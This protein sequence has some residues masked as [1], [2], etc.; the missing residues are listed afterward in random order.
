MAEQVRLR[1]TNLG[2]RFFAFGIPVFAVVAP[3][4]LIGGNVALDMR[5]GRSFEKV[6][7]GSSEQS[8]E[9]LM[10][11]PNKK[12][13]CGEDLWWDDYLGKNDGR[14][15]TESRY[16]YFLSAWGIGYSQDGLVVSKYHYQSE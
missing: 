16:E 9:A 13:A 1:F 15:K 7:T 11:K 8:V 3:F 2:S 10:G 4:V 6:T 5:A 12:R 14:C